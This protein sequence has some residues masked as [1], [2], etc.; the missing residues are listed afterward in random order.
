MT[1]ES[2]IEEKQP[3]KA[4]VLKRPGSRLPEVWFSV[5][6][7]LTHAALTRWTL[8][9]RLAVVHA[10]RRGEQIE[11]AGT[12]RANDQVA[13]YRSD[14]LHRGSG[15]AHALVSS[16]TPGFRLTER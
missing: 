10:P 2:Q 12:V 9:R 16:M 11:R 7:V 6:R 14:L 15:Q 1:S 8:L 13:D 4:P 3:S 5:R